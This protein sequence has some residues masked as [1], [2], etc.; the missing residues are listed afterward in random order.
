[1]C[2]VS[3]RDFGRARETIADGEENAET[4]VDRKGRRGDARAKVKKKIYIY[5]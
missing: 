4:V 1:M 3:E 2:T 5:I